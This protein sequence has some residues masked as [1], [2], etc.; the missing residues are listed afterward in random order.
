M[1]TMAFT[2]S[3]WWVPLRF[4]TILMVPQSFLSSLSL[5][6]SPRPLIVQKLFSWP[7]GWIAVNTG[8]H[9]VCSWETASS[10]SSYVAM[11]DSP[12]KLFQECNN[13]KV[14][15][16]TYCFK[17][18]LCQLCR[19]DA[20]LW[21]KWLSECEL[22][23]L[24]FWSPLWGYLRAVRALKNLGHDYPSGQMFIKLCKI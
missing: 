11:F 1:Q 12:L 20:L 4:H 24:P 14:N 21:G 5:S 22:K 6:L 2:G 15:L 7:S 19:L 23:R 17:D 10:K 16:D 18:L 13:N 8:M 3:S 9:L